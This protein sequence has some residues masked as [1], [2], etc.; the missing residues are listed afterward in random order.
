GSDRFRRSRRCALRRLRLRQPHDWCVPG[1]R[2][3]ARAAAVPHLDVHGLLPAQP[4]RLHHLRAA[5]RRG[6]GAP[7]PPRHGAR[8]TLHQRAA[9]RGD[10]QRRACRT[11]PRAVPL[12]QG[13]RDAAL[14]ARHPA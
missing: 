12:P 3:P 9:V 7:R 2:P 13:G 8:L 6:A 14:L 5:P 1:C 11:Q 10:N 4:K